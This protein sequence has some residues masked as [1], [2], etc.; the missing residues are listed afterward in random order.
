ME[1]GA[2]PI[3][4][5]LCEKAIW[6]FVVGRRNGFF[7]DTIAGANASAN[8][9]SLIE[10][11]KANSVDPYQYLVALFKVLPLAKTADDYEQLLPWNL[12]IGD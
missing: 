5:N 3:D 7:A 11:C 4:N 1:N 8:I 2:W 9:Y 6:P 12:A 10:T